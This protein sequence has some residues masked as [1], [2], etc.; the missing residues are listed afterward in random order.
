[1]DIR[2]RVA[3]WAWLPGSISVVVVVSQVGF[4][5]LRD[6][7][8]TPSS[9]ALAMLIVLLIFSGGRDAR[10]DPAAFVSVVAPSLGLGVLALLLP[11][12]ADFVVDLLAFGIPLS[13]AFA[14]EVVWPFWWSAV[15]RR[16]TL[17]RWWAFDI[18]LTEHVTAS[19]RQA[20]RA[21]ADPRQ[22]ERILRTMRRQTNRLRRRR[23][24]SADWAALRDDLA[25]WEDRWAARMTGGDAGADAGHP[26][27]A[28]LTSRG[29][30]LRSGG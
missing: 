1:V 7:R 9:F 20:E 29:A 4:P 13:V 8:V 10:R 5:A 17:P 12:P 18:K 19:Q 14:G 23:A 6:Q 11:R 21:V 3:E 16:P 2:E 25:D 15:L 24:P 27:A 28:E 22:R 26:T 30:V